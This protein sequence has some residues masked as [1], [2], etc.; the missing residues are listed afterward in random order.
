VSVER[1]DLE[2]KLRQIQDIVDETKGSARA[3]VVAAVGAV[4]LGLLVYLLGRRK[5]KKGKARVEVYRL[6]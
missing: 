3:G 4:A 6:G 5:G 1:T 2:A